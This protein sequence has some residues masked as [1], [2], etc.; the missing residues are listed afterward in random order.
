MAKNNNITSLRVKLPE[1]LYCFQCL[2]QNN[3]IDNEE[4]NDLVE[5]LRDCLSE[6]TG[7]KKNLTIRLQNIFYQPE[8]PMTFKQQVE[9]LLYYINNQ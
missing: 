3:L 7:A 5:S 8:L 9:N 4:K 1:F 6:E 2:Y